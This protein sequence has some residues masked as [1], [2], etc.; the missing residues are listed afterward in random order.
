MQQKIGQ[1]LLDWIR[2]QG[3]KLQGEIKVTTRPANV[4]DKAARQ[5]CVL[6]IN[7]I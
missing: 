1:R 3:A 7:K 2:S 6:I 4:I 5:G